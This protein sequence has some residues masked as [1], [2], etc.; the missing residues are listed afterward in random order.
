MNVSVYIEGQRLDL[1]D[2]EKIEINLQV[3]NVQDIDKIFSDFT[4]SFNVPATPANNAI[5]QHWYDADI[6]GTFNA[7]QRVEAYIEVNSLP[8]RYGSVQL[9]E[10]KLD[11]LRAQSYAITFFSAA[12]N[13]SDLFKDD[14]LSD[15]NAEDF[16]DL[17]HEYGTNIV[18]YFQS[19]PGATDDLYYPLISA[20]NEM[21]LGTN[22]DRDLLKNGNE[23]SYREF[24]P[25]IRLYRIIQAI[26][27]KYGVT[28]S[29][30]FFDRAQFYNL[31]MWLQREAGQIK[32]YGTEVTVDITG[33]GTLGTVGATVNTTTNE[34]NYN[35]YVSALVR[36]SYILIISPS[37]GYE[38][39]PYTVILEN[40]GQ[41]VLR[42]EL[43]GLKGVIYYGER[44]T[45][46]RIRAKVIAQEEFH[47]NPSCRV[48]LSDYNTIPST[49][50]SGTADDIG[51]H[52]VDPYIYVID[53]FPKI[54]VKDF[55]VSLL[56]MFNLAIVPTSG[57]SFY[58]DT[59]DNW[60]SK[61]K[62][63]DITP[64]VNIKT[65]TVKKPDVK[66][67][68]EFKYQKAGA[69]LGERYLTSNTV[70]YGDLQANY[71]IQGS[72]L[73]IESKFENMLF[74]RLQNEA[75]GEISELQAG[76][77]ID[78]NLQPYNG[79][80]Y[81]FYRGG[82]AYTPAPHIHIKPSLT[83]TKVYHTAT[84]DNLLPFQVTSS[85]NFGDDISTYHY[86]PI[87]ES[88]YFNFWK[89]YVEDLYDTKTRILTVSCERMPSAI[90]HRLKLNDKLIF[91]D[92]KY[93]I[94]SAKIDLTTGKA[95]LEL[96]SD[97]S[98]P[99]DSIAETMPL[100]VDTTLYTVDTTL[101]TADQTEV[102]NPVLSYTVNGISRSE[103]LSTAAP[104]S[105]DIKVSANT[106]WSLAKKD[107]GDGV[108]WF[109]TTKV[110][111]FKSDYVRVDLQRNT[112]AT[113][114]AAQIA[115]T[116]AGT[117]YDLDINQQP[118]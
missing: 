23:I 15:L 26:E 32:A 3:K 102:Y 6:D 53:H 73:K 97:L 30:D 13:L 117:D 82:F 108:G 118:I 79:A 52:I 86:T 99:L 95:T 92:K 5:F 31:Y 36:R 58:I 29:R 85:L 24:K 84:E 69:I 60:Y 7:N 105:F 49:S 59:L 70:G 1:F 4:Q 75:T 57:N 35:R 88:L 10:V 43:V 91:R 78:K 42:K 21:S 51:V 94:S 41:E 77:S 89:T 107:T 67:L 55:F 93:K 106:S 39:V 68:I 65:V 45:L 34:V 27:T 83:Q 111:G 81:I 54:K 14:Y 66:K 16:D 74:E 2:D 61:G 90:L 37:T 48:R 104:E 87:T 20:I 22:H 25:A 56:N 40:D 110:V 101:L 80:P 63:Y 72:E 116:I 71:A 9:T 12:V 50:I 103:Y 38:D 46:N 76:Y 47:F 62:M 112:S 18:N 64:Y 33:I 109:T 115:F 96:F 44:D 17:D 28:F 100:T 113:A 19:S 114:R 98:A 8:F 11:Q